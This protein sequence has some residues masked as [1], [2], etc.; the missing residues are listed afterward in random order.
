M[1]AKASPLW[2]L[3]TAGLAAEASIACELRFLNTWI[4]YFGL[5][6]VVVQLTLSTAMHY[7]VFPLA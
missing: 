3:L 7:L 5:Q 6:S 1:A 2:V 4:Q